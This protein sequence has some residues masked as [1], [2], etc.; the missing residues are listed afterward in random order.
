MVRQELNAAA[1]RSNCREFG[2]YLT[3]IDDAQ[4]NQFVWQLLN[5]Q[6]V[7]HVSHNDSMYLVQY[8]ADVTNYLYLSLGAFT[9]RLNV[10]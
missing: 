3:V 4:E 5:G 8:K 6:S 7:S 9:T 10:D 2:G 1:A